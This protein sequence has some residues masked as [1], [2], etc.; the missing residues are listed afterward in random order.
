MNADAN[1]CHLMY[2]QRKSNVYAAL[3]LAT[4]S[5]LTETRAKKTWPTYNSFIMINYIWIW[6]HP[7][8]TMC[9]IVN[10]DIF[11]IIIFMN[12]QQLSDT[13]FCDTSCM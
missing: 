4:S 6:V 7:V 1:L 10:N 8:T 5:S 11:L 3:T 2:F 9:N 12:M 13:S